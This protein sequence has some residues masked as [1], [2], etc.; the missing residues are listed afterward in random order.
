MKKVI[1]SWV[2]YKASERLFIKII[3]LTVENSPIEKVI[4]IINVYIF[5]LLLLINIRLKIQ[6]FYLLNRVNLNTIIIL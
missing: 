6:F 4:S 5:I 2:S 1:G 3:V